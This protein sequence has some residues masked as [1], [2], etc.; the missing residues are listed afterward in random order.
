VQHAV[1]GKTQVMLSWLL[2]CTV[3]TVTSSSL[4]SY[5]VT[6]AGII[7]MVCVW[8]SDLVS[9]VF[10]LIVLFGIGPLFE[11]LPKVCDATKL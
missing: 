2:Y 1:G 8:I 11:Q 7:L 4:G 10:I 9:C 3:V 6:T 5:T